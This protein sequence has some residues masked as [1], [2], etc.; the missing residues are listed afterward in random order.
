MEPT[1]ES[2]DFLIRRD[3]EREEVERVKPFWKRTPATPSTI[4]KILISVLMISSTFFCAGVIIG[5]SQ[6]YPVLISSGVLHEKYCHNTNFTAS[7][8]CPDQNVAL[9][10]LFFYRSLV[11]I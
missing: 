4:V 2:I 6:L 1:P 3:D 7:A 9:T 5:Y 10:V 8:V 11:R